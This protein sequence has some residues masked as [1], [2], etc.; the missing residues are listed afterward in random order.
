MAST[1]R[2]RWARVPPALAWKR[3]GLPTEWVPVLERNTAP[4]WCEP[5]LPLVNI[6]G[7][8]GAALPRIAA[9]LGS[10]GN[11]LAQIAATLST[12][13]AAEAQASHRDETNAVLSRLAELL[14]KAKIGQSFSGD[15][16]LQIENDGKDT[17]Q[18]ALDIR[19]ALED[20]SMADFGR[21]DRWGQT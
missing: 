14:A 2:Q 8:D 21:T 15:I 12:I 10:T 11:V 19:R 18:L 20:I 6:V 9:S 13:T 16:I 1:D 5:G 3:P 17:P 7:G 4:M